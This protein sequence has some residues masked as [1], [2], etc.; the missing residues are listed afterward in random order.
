MP[1]FRILLV[2]FLAIPLLEIYL[3]IKVG[4]SIGALNTV[5]LVVLTAVIGAWLLR[6]QGISTLRR[7]QATAARGEMPA[8][9]MLEGMMLFLS[10]ALLLTPG[11]F[12]D[13][14]GFILLVPPIRKALALWFLERSGTIVKMHTEHHESRH[15]GRYIDGDYD[16]RDD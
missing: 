9:E 4:N 3:L 5:I 11:F 14:I 7:V 13:T 10:G 16:R 2:L 8:I 6:L 15:S 12:T 1:I